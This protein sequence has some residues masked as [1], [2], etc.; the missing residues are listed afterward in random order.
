MTDR[1]LA[2]AISQTSPNCE[3]FQSSRV[4]VNCNH[5]HYHFLRAQVSSSSRIST[6]PLRLLTRGPTLLLPTRLSTQAP[7]PAVDHADLLELV[8]DPPCTV[9]R[10]WTQALGRA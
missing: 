5:P 4:V 2:H 1:F 7:T 6:L 9:G 3:L 8:E 10:T